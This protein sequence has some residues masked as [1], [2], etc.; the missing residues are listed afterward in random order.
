MYRFAIAP[1][2]ILLL[3]AGCVSKSRYE[4]A[5]AALAACD[6]EKAEARADAATWERRFDRAS[7]RW[8]DLESSLSEAL[9]AALDEFHEERQRIL[10]LVPEQVQDDVERYLEDYF[11]TVMKGF[12]LLNDDNA[13]IKL[14]LKTTQKALD[15]V[16]A[17]ARGIRTAVDEEALADER[18]QRDAMASRLAEISG[19]LAGIVERV[20][21]FD[22]SRITCKGCPE[23]LRLNSKQR[24][25]FLGFH[26]QLVSDLSDLQSRAAQ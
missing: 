9:P 17:D 12:E 23:R 15:A 8:D 10:T 25:E 2:L 26:G 11:N 6:Q 13:E 20:A 7:S 16:G 18:I 1:L 3:S 21:E 14:E 4:E 24:S 19:S 22:H 5:Q